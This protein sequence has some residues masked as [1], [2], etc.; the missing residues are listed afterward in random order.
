MKDMKNIGCYLLTFGFAVCAIIWA[1]IFPITGEE[2]GYCV[3]NYY[4]LFPILSLL[5][6]LILGFK[7]SKYKWT[8]PP[9]VG[10]IGSLMPF[11]IFHSMWWGVGLVGIIPA[12]IGLVIGS[13][14]MK[15]K[16]Q[17]LKPV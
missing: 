16:Q 15:L 17:S 5:C 12:F 13:V 2:M 6:G 4:L 7:E 1:L 9:F 8:Y 14:V 11:P 10:L 3:L